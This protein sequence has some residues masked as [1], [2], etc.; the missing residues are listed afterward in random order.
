MRLIWKI[1]VVQLLIETG[2]KSQIGKKRKVKYIIR[3]EKH[4][5]FYKI[6]KKNQRSFAVM[7]FLN[8]PTS[9]FIAK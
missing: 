4:D 7:D 2:N 5:K 1:V 6:E 9:T 3:R 8:K